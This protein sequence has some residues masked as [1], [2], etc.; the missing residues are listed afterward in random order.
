M[1]INFRYFCKSIFIFLFI[2]TLSACSYNNV[3][4]LRDHAKAHQTYYYDGKLEDIYNLAI[5]KYNECGI[6]VSNTFIDHTAGTA[7]AS[8]TNVGWGWYAHADF[9]KEEDNCIKIDSYAALD[10]GIPGNFMKITEHAVK[11]RPGCPSD[12]F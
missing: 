12:L 2:P 7:G 11:A 9:K 1:V 6:P 5:Q 10:M 4:E 3:S 8:Y